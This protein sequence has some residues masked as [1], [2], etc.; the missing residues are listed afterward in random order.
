MKPAGLRLVAA[1]VPAIL[2]LAPVAAPAQVF[3]SLGTRALGMGGAFVAV[4]DD[5][6]A[7]YWN[8][9]GLAT[10]PF[11]SV[12]LDWQD[13]VWPGGPRRETA[14]GLEGSSV[15]VGVAT[16]PVGLVY[17]RQRVEGTGWQQLHRDA[18]NGGPRTETG[19]GPQLASLVAHH[20]ALALV[21]TIVPGVV[22]G[23]ALKLVR[24]SAAEGGAPVGAP[25]GTADLD[26]RASSRFDADL[27]VMAG[28][29]RIRVGLVARNLRQP[30]FE[31]PQ[32]T[33]LALQRQV[34]AG[35]AWL[36]TDALTL[37]LDADLTRSVAAPG[38][39]R[40][41]AAGAE[42][43]WWDRR[44]GTRAGARVDTAG[45][46]RPVGTAGVSAGLARWVWVEGQISRGGPAADR[47]WGV[48][49]RAGF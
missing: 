1:L 47:S 42:A 25:S 24:G 32:G 38:D 33:R 22:V 28:T 46:G 48:A 26:R 39:T 5:A 17:Y 21:Q 9:A 30:G 16:L 40:N 11:F 31:T 3:E 23:S 18:T 8:P 4:A 49:L 41:L 2:G 13:L 19:A 10:G 29:R 44:L 43:W 27:G 37:A 15:I 12:V 45:A 35:V 14:G 34:R 6:T 36:A 7:V 20:T